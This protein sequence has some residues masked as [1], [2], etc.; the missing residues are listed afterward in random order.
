M[1]TLFTG[2]GKTE[3]NNCCIQKAV[4]EGLG[5]YTF[6]EVEA[7]ASSAIP[8][9]KHAIIWAATAWNDIFQA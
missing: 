7:G 6:S 8:N 3:K 2:M 9:F 1:Y 4:K 5:H